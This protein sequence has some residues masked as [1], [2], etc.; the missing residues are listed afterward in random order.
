MKATHQEHF[1]TITWQTFLESRSHPHEDISYDEIRMWLCNWPL[2]GTS[3]G[4]DE[5]IAMGE[6]LDKEKKR[7]D[8]QR[9]K[10]VMNL[11]VVWNLDNT[12]V[13]LNGHESDTRVCYLS[14]EHISCVVMSRLINIDFTSHMYSNLFSGCS[15][16]YLA[17]L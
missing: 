11:E 7:Q 6:K 4:Y 13:M 15:T 12:Y 16:Y 5:V 17:R 14:F 3:C 2:H 9:R 8:M 1:T 10:K